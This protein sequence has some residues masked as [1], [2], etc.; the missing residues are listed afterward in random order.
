M[1]V[2]TDSGA[3]QYF[4]RLLLLP[5]GWISSFRKKMKAGRRISHRE[6][7]LC[8]FFS[9][10]LLVVYLSAE[11]KLASTTSSIAVVLT[12]CTEQSN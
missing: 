5:V 3:S 1:L 11:L 12:A 2:V 10:Q 6:T 8:P 9:L 7:S 4:D